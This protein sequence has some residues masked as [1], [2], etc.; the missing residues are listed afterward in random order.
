[1]PK[2]YYIIIKHKSK[3]EKT[4]DADVDGANTNYANE[5][6]IMP[7]NMRLWK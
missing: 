5:H 1:M 7:T 4:N 3:T 2:L 6:A